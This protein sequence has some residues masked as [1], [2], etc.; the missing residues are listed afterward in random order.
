MPVAGEPLVRRILAWLHHHEIVDVVINL[1]H[2]AETL[3]A[4][5]G[6][7]SDIG[8]RVRYSWEAP[9]VLGSAGGPR[10]ALPIMRA[11]QF[12]LV[13]GDT[14]TDVD[15]GE[16]AATHAASGALVTL[17]LVRNREFDRYG[18]VKVDK[19]G[20][21]VS[22]SRRGP[23]SRDS[24]HFIGVQAVDASVF[25]DLPDGVPLNTIGGVYDELIRT[26]PGAVR[27]HCCDA[28]F[29]DVGTAR[30]YLRTSHAL[31]NGA[32][33]MGRRVHIDASAQVTGSILWDDVEVGADVRLTECIAADGVRVPPGTRYERTI[34]QQRGDDLVVT[35]IEN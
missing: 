31:S 14:L 12:L 23:E 10:H 6:D 8:V 15:P 11:D 13:N 25:G 26:R 2:R 16:V 27:A 5:V 32:L 1:H 4:V 7:G 20:C 3:T 18:G 9:L 28:A 22:F 17:A 34:L 35:P 21:I 29:W 33:D 19:D 24:W 30:D